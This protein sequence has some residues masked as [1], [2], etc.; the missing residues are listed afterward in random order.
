MTEK[1]L[2]NANDSGKMPEEKKANTAVPETAEKG[3]KMVQR[4]NFPCKATQFKPGWEGGPG[5]PPGVKHFTTLLHK[6][7]D[8]EI[9]EQAAI[10]TLSKEYGIANATRFISWVC[11]LEK[12]AMDLSGEPA[13]RRQALTDLLKFFV[14]MPS[15]DVDLGGQKDNPLAI[16]AKEKSIVLALLGT[17]PAPKNDGTEAGVK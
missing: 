4:Q 10:D 14:K 17:I 15:Q 7:G 16:E 12:M 2:N 8:A 11:S 6:F 9:T 1:I 13:V 5:H 3:R